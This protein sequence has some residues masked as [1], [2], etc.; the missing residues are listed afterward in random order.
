[1]ILLDAGNGI[2]KLAEMHFWCDVSDEGNVT[3]HYSDD[4]LF[5]IPES[6][7]GTRK[8]LIV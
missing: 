5:D 3:G 2:M 7:L 1:M 8:Y 4:T 6:Q